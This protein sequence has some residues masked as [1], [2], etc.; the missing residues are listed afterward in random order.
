MPPEDASLIRRWR[1]AAARADALTNAEALADAAAGSALA[2]EATRARDVL[3]GLDDEIRRRADELAAVLNPSAEPMDADEVSHALPPRTALLTWVHVDDDVLAFALPAGRGPRCHHTS[4]DADDLTAMLN[5]FARACRDGA[6]WQDAAADVARLLIAPFASEIGDADAVLVVP[7][8]VGHRVPVHLLPLD[9]ELLGAHRT[10]SYLPATSIIR[11]LAGRPAAGLAAASRFIVGNPTQ[12]AWTPPGGTPVAYPPLGFAETE[13]RMITRPGDVSLI[14]PAATKANVVTDIARHRVVHFASHAHVTADAPQLSAV[15]L[16]DGD[17]LSVADLMGT[18]LPADLV[19]LSA[20][21]TGTGT[22]T[23]GDEVVG[24]TRGLFAAGARQAVVSLWPANDLATCLLMR[25]FY[26]G[27][28]GATAAES[29]RRACQELA[30]LDLD[31]QVDELMALQAE[32][33]DQETPEP[34]LEKIERAAAM[35]RGSDASEAASV[36]THPRVWAPF[37]HLG[38]P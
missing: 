34:V 35:R 4:M 24:L 23:E 32:L 20:C 33:A 12:M 1:E 37:V 8:L 26:A 10:V 6:P 17:T 38:L 5:G 16:A 27:L 29:L 21:D 7:F 11:N 28:A 13:A 36:F 30:A 14:G 31:Q 9:G 2:R 3:G 15:L 22:L 19:V 25:R 18:G